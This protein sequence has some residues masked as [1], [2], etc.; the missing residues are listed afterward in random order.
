MLF[1][2]SVISFGTLLLVRPTAPV[3]GGSPLPA[4]GRTV[5]ALPALTYGAV[6]VA[7]WLAPG[8]VSD[9]GP[10]PAGPMGLGFVGSWAAFLALCAAFTPV[11]HHPWKAVRVRIAA[12]VVFPAAGL[13]SVLASLEG[14][15]IAPAT[16]VA[17][18]LGLLTIGGLSVGWSGRRV[19]LPTTRGGAVR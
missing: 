9:H 6:A 3:G 8:V 15:R 14:L 16:A 17:T 7:L 10:V 11:R 13:A 12:L 19:E 5:S 4:W 1:V 2:A 18:G